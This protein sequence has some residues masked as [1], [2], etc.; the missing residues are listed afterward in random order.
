VPVGQRYDEVL[1]AAAAAPTAPA[2]LGS[3]VGDRP[4][5]A[6]PSDDELSAAQADFNKAQEQR[7]EAFNRPTNDRNGRLRSIL[8]MAGVALQQFNN[9]RPGGNW[10]EF[11]RTAAGAGGIALGTAFHPSIDEEL[12]REHDLQAADEALKSA[13]DNLNTSSQIHNRDSLATDREERQKLARSSYELKRLHQEWQRRVGD[14]RLSN[15]EKAQAF[16]EEMSRKGY[17]LR[18]NESEFSQ[19]YREEMLNDRDRSYD[20]AVRRERRQAEEGSHRLKLAERREQRIRETASKGGSREEIVRQIA[21]IDRNSALEEAEDYSKRAAE[22]EATGDEED[23]RDAEE[24]R[25]KE[26]QAR[27]RAAKSAVK[28]G[29]IGAQD[30]EADAR[31]RYPND[32]A[33]QKQFIEFV[34]TKQSLGVGFVQ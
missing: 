5:S 4:G 6:P 19:W 34:K 29:A 28:A 3:F 27:A 25:H 18:M 22:L 17:D 24:L 14:K 12:G 13:R 31:R 8:K 33:K 10:G 30:I 26:R 21:E 23:S 11:V 20:L 15:S 1:N 7:N 2:P 16:R 32:P 9:F